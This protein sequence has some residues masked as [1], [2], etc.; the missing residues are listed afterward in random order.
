MRGLSICATILGPERWHKC[1]ESLLLSS[2]CLHYVFGCASLALVCRHTFW[3][4]LG[5]AR[6]WK[7]FDH[8]LVNTTTTC[9]PSR[10]PMYLF[11]K[12]LFKTP[13]K[14]FKR[15]FWSAE[16]NQ[17]QARRLLQGNHTLSNLLLEALYACIIVI[18][19]EVE[20]GS[21]QM[22][23]TYFEELNSLLHSF[24]GKL[25]LTKVA[26]KDSQV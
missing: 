8:V 1:R 9:S 11:G 20:N 10:L 5:H 15:T 2:S 23:S 14:P 16:H 17:V 26:R 22:A 18:P 25:G 21:S 24:E 13:A 19:A 7:S 12:V 4:S 3:D 6:L